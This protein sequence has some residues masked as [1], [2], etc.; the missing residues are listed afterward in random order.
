MKTVSEFEI[1]YQTSEYMYIVDIG[2][3]CKSV[4]NDAEN[5]LKFL[6][7]YHQ[8]GSRRLI[9]RDSEGQIDE[10]LHDNGKFMRFAPGHSGIE[11]QKE[12]FNLG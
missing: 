7:K 11:K 1:I 8:L 12:W 5:V 4:T 2:L 10:I 9:Y 6:T 3:V